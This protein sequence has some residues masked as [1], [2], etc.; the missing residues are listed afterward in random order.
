MKKSAL[1]TDIGKWC[2][3]FTEMVSNIFVRR[4]PVDI[5][6]IVDAGVKSLQGQE[7]PLV[8]TAVY[9]AVGT[10]ID[11]AVDETIHDSSLMS[12]T[13]ETILIWR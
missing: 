12:L 5:L 1:V 2:F 6:E 13:Q 10:Q 8:A 3:A 4:A 9:R 7:R 11:A